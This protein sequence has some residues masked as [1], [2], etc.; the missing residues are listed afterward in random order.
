MTQLFECKGTLEKKRI[1]AHFLAAFICIG[2]ALLPEAALSQI[3]SNV[4]TR[5][6]M[7]RPSGANVLGTG[8][9][10]EVS[11]RQYLITAKHVVHGMKP[12]DTIEIRMD[13]GSWVKEPVTVLTDNSLAD[14]AV[15]V[16]SK[17]L[18]PTYPLEPTDI[19]FQYGQ[20][21]YFV[22]FPYGLFT[23]ASN[24][25]NGR[26]IGFVKK[27][28]LSGTWNEG[29]AFVLLLDGY[30]NKGFSG[31]PIVFRDLTKQEIVFKVAG[32]VSAYRHEEIPVIRKPTAI[33]EDGK[34]ISVE[35]VPMLVRQNTGILIGYGISSALKLIAKNPIGPEV[36]VKPQ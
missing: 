23:K 19:G 33:Q 31:G 4:F 35:D 22:G 14:V 12:K 6:M 15:L 21:M 34:S 26:P 7:I 30:N 2:F 5:V 13:D 9:T 10:I 29:D 16:P 1:H 20:D 11:S 3:T 28:I 27:A 32:V 17:Q 25:N 24:A 8:F 18:T 36:L